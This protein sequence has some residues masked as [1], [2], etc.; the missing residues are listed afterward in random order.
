[1]LCNDGCL[2]MMLLTCAS[3]AWHKVKR[4]IQGAQLT[5][6]GHLSSREAEEGEGVVPIQEEKGNTM[7]TGHCWVSEVH[8]LSA[9]RYK[10]GEAGDCIMVEVFLFCSALVIFL[11]KSGKV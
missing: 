6:I 5:L 9:S 8:E 4:E 11:A 7:Q 10:C 2:C 3:A 1:M